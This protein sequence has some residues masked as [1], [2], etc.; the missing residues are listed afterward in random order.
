MCTQ[1]N[2]AI[3]SICD[4]HHETIASLITATIMTVCPHR[5]RPPPPVQGL[6]FRASSASSVVKCL[7]Q[8][9]QQQRV[10]H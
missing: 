10:K 6:G 2:H 8:Q 7:A 3:T 4:N 5:L 1:D 9:M